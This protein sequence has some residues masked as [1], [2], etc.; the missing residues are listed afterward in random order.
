M[1][2]PVPAVNNVQNMNGQS[3][4]GYNMNLL[5]LNDL[6]KIQN[7]IFPQHNM[8]RNGSDTSFELLEQNVMANNHD[9][10]LNA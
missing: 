1:A 4:F 2:V 3:G 6:L 7:S 5:H 10:F 8:C 9:K